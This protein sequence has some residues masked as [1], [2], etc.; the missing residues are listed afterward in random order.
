MLRSG[1]TS[2]SKLP[3]VGATIFS[4][5]GQLAEQY[6]AIN[7]SQGA[8][9]FPCDPALRAL[10]S[11]AME[12]GHNQYSAMPGYLPLRE[13]LALKVEQLYGCR[14]DAGCNITVVG[15]AS[16][17]LYSAISALVHAGDEVIFFEPAFD[18]YAPIVRLQG[19][20]PIGIKLRAPD[21]RVDW[22]EVRAHISP[23]T[24]MIIVNTPHNP[25]ATVFA[26]E[27]I[28]ELVAVT[29]G[30]DIVVLSDEVYEHIVFDG[31]PHRSM[32]RYPE[33]SERAVVVGSFGKTFHVTGWR[34]GFCLA[35]SELTEELRKIHQFMMY[36]ADT[37]MQV[38]FTQYLADAERYLS[39]AGFYQAKRDLL[40]DELAGSRLQLLPSA[41]SFFMLADYRA[42]SDEPDSQFV[43]RLIREVGVSTIPMSAFYSDGTDQGV[44]RLSFAK[45]DDTLRAGARALCRI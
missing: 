28:A 37:P 35:P 39:L 29:R 1:I 12:A 27:D 4:V 16:E 24:R 8:P 9:S 19:A 10:V 15:S 36:S 17:G 45:D 33:L 5:I 31:Q 6:Q 23:R 26:D 43:Q 3:D 18:S 41:G 21:F 14:Y 11:Q 20:R 7:L 44:I 30:T 42:I 34:V 32:A 25:T 2:T 38:A 40:R 13:A 22:Q